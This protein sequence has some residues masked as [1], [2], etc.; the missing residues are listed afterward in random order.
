MMSSIMRL[1][2]ATFPTVS[3]NL[4]ENS[5]IYNKVLS[6][7]VFLVLLYIYTTATHTPFTFSLIH[8]LDSFTCTYLLEVD[9]PAKPVYTDIPCS[10][11]EHS[12][13]LTI[14]HKYSSFNRLTHLLLSY[15]LPSVSTSLFHLSILC[16]FSY[17][18]TAI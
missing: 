9:H 14:I 2:F 6:Q 15:L 11:P 4:K 17:F 13:I 1:P 3:S 8:K 16:F 12:N 10:L 18:T 5:K 7:L